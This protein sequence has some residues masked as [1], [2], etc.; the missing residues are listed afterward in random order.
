MPDSKSRMEGHRKLEV[1]RKETHDTG[2]DPFVGQRSKVKVTRLIN[3]VT[4]NQPYLRNGRPTNFKLG[5][6][7][8]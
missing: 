6:Q 7:L 5:I 2:H 4:E 3:A 8:E 1:G